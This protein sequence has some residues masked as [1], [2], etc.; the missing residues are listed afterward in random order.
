MR[1]LDEKRRDVALTL[2][3]KRHNHVHSWDSSS[4]AM[5]CAQWTEI[6]LQ[7]IRSTG[8]H[9]RDSNELVIG[10]FNKFEP[11]DTE[12][13]S[14]IAINLIEMMVTQGDLC[15]KNLGDLKALLDAPEY[16]KMKPFANP[17]NLDMFES[18]IYIFTDSVTKMGKNGGHKMARDPQL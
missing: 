3:R 6:L 1:Q 16:L 13:Y 12:T 18:E 14:N 15:F 17:F 4:A 2:Y 9:N 5:A 10:L 7:T 11:T 8:H